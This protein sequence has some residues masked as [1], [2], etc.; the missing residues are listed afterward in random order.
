MR[1]LFVNTAVYQKKKIVIFAKKI[2]NFF[3]E[4]S[5]FKRE[6]AKIIDKNSQLHYAMTHSWYTTTC[7]SSIVTSLQERELSLTRVC[8][9]G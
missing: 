5:I 1:I 7:L 9:V 4:M 6:T 8:L 3:V 2:L